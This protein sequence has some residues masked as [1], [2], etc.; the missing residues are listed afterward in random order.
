MSRESSEGRKPATQLRDKIA[1]G[2]KIQ[3]IASFASGC[4][5]GV[6]SAVILQPTDVLKT[7]MQVRNL[8]PP[9]TRT[10]TH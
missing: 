3:T 8:G 9:Q 2:G 4:A 6:L 1:K 5:S 7:K 10:R